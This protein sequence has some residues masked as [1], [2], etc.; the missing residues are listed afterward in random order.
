MSVAGRNAPLSPVSIGG[1]EWS[2]SSKVLF[3]EESAPFPS[4]ARGNLAS[5]PDSG[6]LHGTMSMNGFPT[7]PRSTGGPSPPPSIGRSS[8]GT[9]TFSA[10]SDGGNRNSA[11]AD[12]DES[13]LNEHYLALRVFLNARDSSS[14]QQPNKAR[15]KL[16][17]LS[18]VQ[19]YELSTDVF[20][21]LMRRQAS[22]RTPSN[23]PGGPA[24]FLLPEKSFHPK[25]NQARQRL[26]SLGPPRFRDLAADVFHELERRFPRFIG[27]DIPRSGSAMSMRGPPG[28]R[29][30]TPVS[31]SMF[32]PRGQSRMRRPS[33][34]SSSRGLPPSDGY[35]VQP[36][37]SVSN[38]DYGRPTPK[39]LNQN[40]TIVPNKSTMVE[41]GD[42]NGA[43]DDRADAFSLDRISNKRDL[44][45]SGDSAVTSEIDKKAI[46]DYQGQI[47][48]LRD[49]LDSME[50][51]MRKK[52]DEMN[53][54]LDGERTRTTAM[55]LE[56]QEW[57]NARVK[58]ETQ[59]AEAQS[60]NKSLEQELD[61]MR[62]D[63]DGESR[64]L[65]DQVSALQQTSR[66]GRSGEGSAEVQIE[67]DELRESLRQQRQVTEQVRREA[68]GFLLEMRALSQQ[69]GSAYEKEAEMEKNIEQLEREV[70]EWRSRYTR[71][72]TQ[73]RNMRGS[74][75]GLELDQDAA[76][77]VRDK[78]FLDPNGLVK[79]LHVTKYQTSIDELL[80][81]AR[82][83]VP[84]KVMD[85][86]KLVVVSVRRITRDVDE[87]ASSDGQAAQQQAKLKAKVSSSA[88]G[89]ITASKNFAAA[90]G[91]SPVSLVDAAASNL[92]VAIVDLVRAA[93]IR[94]TPA[95][96]LEDD[97][98]GTVTPVE[99]ASFFSPRSTTQATTQESLPPP[100]PFRGIGGI[101][102]S[103]ESSAYSPVS[104]PR[105]SVEP[106][107]SNG[108]NGITNGLGYL[109]LDT[110]LSG[111]YGLQRRD[112]RTEDLKIYLEDQTALLVS[113]VQKLVGYVRGA[114]DIENITMQIESIGVVVGRIAS[115]S[116]SNGYGNQVSRL[117]ECR[118][119]LIES[120]QRGREL[121]RSGAGPGD[122]AWRL[123]SQTLPP[124]AFE[125]AREA[126]ELVQRI[127]RQ[128]NAVNRDDEFS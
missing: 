123:W 42:D 36:S 5:P 15:D 114:G 126:K 119:R 86:M 50:D 100:P 43:D 41:E 118:Q 14:R 19:F 72:K 120:N 28:S 18:S 30:D 111:P 109:G 87:S 67:N 89:L 16:L 24:S 81:T 4:S 23:G 54:V 25:R 93:K 79:D 90:A 33:D 10:R 35:S 84:E 17:R 34:A 128:P 71:T 40:N 108:A 78:G 62:E 6:S 32:P 12:I 45:R 13:I 1:S 49:K 76:K 115:E 27:G 122:G 57:A 44:K 106:Y 101:R 92:T 88:N 83:D 74:S 38:G 82:R 29:N 66:S 98:D 124:I 110:S 73:L 20:D 107:P 116:K 85:A 69:S 105:E 104:S 48:D 75:V 63:H 112:S 121:S 9:N 94:T 97:D 8:N 103:A 52:D 39:Q 95:N 59:L 125:L 11:R 22:A 68:Q 55:N 37:P 61:R 96:E 117:S 58:L 70:R 2:F 77:Y 46:Q 127:D 21:E 64:Q 7:G 91:I 65:R 102:G 31:G 51:L 60:L 80:Q 26:S 53:S 3:T 47:Q 56:K 113:D 99:S